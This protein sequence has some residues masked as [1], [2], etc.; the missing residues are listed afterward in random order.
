MSQSLCGVLIHLVF[1]TKK[2]Q[3]ILDED[4]CN[5][6]Y[7]YISTLLENKNCR[8]YKI[9]GIAN[10]IHILC[11]IDK[12]YS[13]CKLVEEI[14]STSSKWL[15]TKNNKFKSFGW[16]NGYGAFS[17]SPTHFKHVYSY[18]DKQKEH[19]KQINFEDEFLRLLEKYQ[20][21]YDNKYLWD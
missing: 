8:S 21:T 5:E 13:I 20:I 14:K 7:R 17:I 12:K 16:Q 10:H 4:I 15:K 18:I 2:R 3:N 11:A 1:S 19:H 9:G 6:L